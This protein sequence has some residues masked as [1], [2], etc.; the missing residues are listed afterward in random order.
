MRRALDGEES[1]T[2]WRRKEQLFTAVAVPMTIGP[3]LVG[4]LVSGYRLD[5][6]VAGQVRRLSRPSEPEFG[7][8]RQPPSQIPSIRPP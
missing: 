5:D 7:L 1:A 2:L 4:V 3:E 8:A 6:A